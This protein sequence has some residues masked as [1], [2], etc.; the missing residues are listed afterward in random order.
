MPRM[1]QRWIE[2]ELH[3]EGPSVVL[4]VFLRTAVAPALV[5][6]PVILGMLLDKELLRS[7]QVPIQI[8]ARWCMAAT[9]VG[10]FLAVL[11]W[12]RP[13]H[14]RDAAHFGLGVSSVWRRCLP[15]LMLPWMLHAALLVWA[16]LMPAATSGAPA[17]DERVMRWATLMGIVGQVPWILAMRHLASLGDYLRD[18]RIRRST[19]TW[20]WIWIAAMLLVAARVPFQARFGAGADLGGMLLAMASLSRVGLLWG[21]VNGALMAWSCAEALALAHEEVARD[22]RRAER[23]ENRYRTPD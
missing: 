18:V 14:T 5:L 17:P 6:L 15:A 7:M 16:I 22:E 1:H 10:A 23:E 12:T 8:D 3:R 13:I 11:L 9:G 21:S 4:P 2:G 19:I 20:T